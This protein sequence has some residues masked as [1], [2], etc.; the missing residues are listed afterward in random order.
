MTITINF[1]VHVLQ[2]LAPLAAGAALVI[3]KPGGHLDGA[4]VAGLLAAHRVTA[5]LGS[6]PTLVRGRRPCAS[7]RPPPR[8]PSHFRASRLSPPA[9]RR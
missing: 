3:A 8:A 6:V 7:E 9:A 1:D 5:V 4:H 2:A